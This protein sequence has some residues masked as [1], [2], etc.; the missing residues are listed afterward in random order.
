MCVR[1]G[2]RQLAVASPTSWLSASRAFGRLFF[3]TLLCP[4]ID[5]HYQ[6]RTNRNFENVS[7]I[8]N[9]SK[10]GDQNVNNNIDFLANEYSC[11]YHVPNFGDDSMF[12]NL[13]TFPK[14]SMAC[15]FCSVGTHWYYAHSSTSKVYQLFSQKAVVLYAWQILERE[16]KMYWLPG[17]VL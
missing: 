6:R 5:P 16:I 4:R 10:F 17:P 9:V 12:S 3:R 11:P 8:E 13:E 14:L 1:S 15:A 2:T 7:I